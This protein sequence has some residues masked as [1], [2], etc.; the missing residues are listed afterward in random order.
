VS[1]YKEWF[2]SVVRL[3]LGSRVSGLFCQ[4]RA[5][6]IEDRVVNVLHQMGSV[7]IILHKLHQTL[8]LVV[9]TG[10]YQPGSIHLWLSKEFDAPQP[11]N[12]CSKVVENGE[13]CAFPRLEIRLLTPMRSI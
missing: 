4:P 13:A 1:L 11:F 6:D 8:E 7:R 10:D 2:C 12:Y 5:K 3:I 9:L